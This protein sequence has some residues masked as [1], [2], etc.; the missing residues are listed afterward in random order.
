M[1]D[2]IFEA[3]REFGVVKLVSCLS[4]C[5]FPAAAPNPID[6]SMI[7][8]GPPHASNEGYAYAK[9]MID[10]LNRCY[11]EE[12]GSHF[13]AVVPT[14][15]YGP[16]DNF[17]IDDGH[18]IPGLIHKCFLAQRDGGDF[19]VWGSG[20][21]LRQFIASSDV[22]ALTVWALRSY[23]SVEPVIL[24]PD[25]A[26]ELTIRDVAQLVAEAMGFAGKIVF[27]ASKA[28][29]QHK[30]TA[31]NARLRSHL[32][33]YAFKPIRDGVAEAVAWFKANYETARK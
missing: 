30:K 5:I 29:G 15:I 8:A 28:D 19:V 20:T 21:P 12:Y 25:E 4:T 23:D 24:A 10:V 17:N 31:S 18:V 2:N 26:D 33:G 3:C 27:D 32:P 16:H 13:T 9:R 11:A 7:H 1:N 14:N 6:E 22:A